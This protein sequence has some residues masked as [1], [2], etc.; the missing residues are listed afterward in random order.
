[1]ARVAITYDKRR[2]LL[3]WLP[4]LLAAMPLHYYALADAMPLIIDYAIATPLLLSLML[5]LR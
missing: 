5:S 1:M 4:L 3:R 2:D